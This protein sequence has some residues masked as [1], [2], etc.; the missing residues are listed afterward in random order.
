MSDLFLEGRDLVV[1]YDGRTIL[2]VDR[3]GVRRG[4]CLAIIG[5]NGAG[6]STLLRVLGLL[7]RPASGEVRMDG[8]MV[9]WRVSLLASRRRF[10]SAFQEPLLLDATVER[11]V[12]LALELRRLPGREVRR[13]GARWMER[14]GIAHLARRQA[15]TLS[16]GEAQRASLA[17]AF[18]IEPDA[19]LLDEPFSALD[20]P[21]REGILQDFQRI[22]RESPVTTLLVTHDRDEALCLGS[23]VAVMLDGRL[24]QVGSS[25]EVFGR[26]VSEAVARFVGVENLLPGR[27]TADVGGLLTVDTGQMRLRVPGRAPVGASV[28]VCLRPEDVVLRPGTDEG[29]RDSTLNHLSGRIAELF[30][31]GSQVRVRVDCVHPMVVMV[32]GQSVRDLGLAPGVPVTASFKASAAHLI[33]HDAQA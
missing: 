15:R 27:I 17:R 7:E 31:L 19:L 25:P 11:N 13:R 24:P 3:I 16:G 10:A 5:P 32:T 23:R 22:M 20:P 4:E 9:D 1:R 14:F 8:A 30:V 26:P 12:G 2:A 21:T 33:E 6:K 18:A 28:L 29:P